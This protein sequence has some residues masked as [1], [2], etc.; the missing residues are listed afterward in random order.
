M[1]QREMII[2]HVKHHTQAS[3]YASVSNI[4]I[5]EC[6]WRNESYQDFCERI[7]AE[8]KNIVW[9]HNPITNM[10]YFMEQQ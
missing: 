8:V 7:C 4:A 6:L 9:A 2:A 5:Y 3:K 10:F 1:T